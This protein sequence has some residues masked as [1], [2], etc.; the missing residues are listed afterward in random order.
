MQTLFTDP[1]YN[2]W[3]DGWMD[4]WMCVCVSVCLCLC[5]CVCECVCALYL[6]LLRRKMHGLHSHLA[7]LSGIVVI[8]NSRANTQA[9]KDPPQKRMMHV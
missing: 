9:A 7:S 5:V 1:D 2:G 6:L 3:M 8:V 4:G